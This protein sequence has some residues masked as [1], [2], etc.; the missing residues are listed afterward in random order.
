[1]KIPKLKL[2]FI[3][4]SLAFAYFWI[5]I[6][7]PYLTYRGLTPAQSFSLMSIYQFMGV[8][9]EY[10][11]G[12]IGDKFG[13]KRVTFLANTLNMLSMLVMSLNGGYYLYLFAL[14]LLATGNGFSSGNDMGLLKGVSHNIK[15]DT[16]NYNA[17]MDLVLF[18]SSII[19]GFISKFSFELALI[20]SGLLM[21][22]ANIPLYLLKNG[23]V[24]EKNTD[25]LFI[26]IKE[27]FS[28]FKQANIRQIFILIALF[29]GFSFT[30]KSIVGGFGTLFGVDVATI[31]VLI[32]VG[33]LVRSIGSKLYAEK[34][35]IPT[36]LGLNLVGIALILVGL[37]PTYQIVI[38]LLLLCQVMFGYITSKMDGDLHDI[39]GDRVRASVF[40]LKR[41]TMRL[42]ASGY[43]IL[44]GIAIQANRFSFLM[45]ITGIILMIGVYIVKDY[46]VRTDTN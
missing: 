3:G 19:G 39:V 6:A 8:I 46:V 45:I 35:H 44:Y 25:S 15:K 36:A 30:I 38:A 24:Q 32:G 29:G 16:A 27:G 18:F 37:I 2:F 17:L 34:P 4:Q 20:V 28:S 12:V 26:I 21:F 23:V 7:I 5:A 33:G 43:L 31:G 14:L 10:P 22:S 9:L 11:T 1:M 42:I 41:L 40:S 13:Y